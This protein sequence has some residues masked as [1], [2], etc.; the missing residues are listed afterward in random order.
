MNKYLEKIT[1]RVREI[2]HIDDNTPYSLERIDASS[3]V[4]PCRLDVLMK[5]YY[6]YSK[7]NGMNM[8]FATEMFKKQ[9]HSITCFSDKEN[10]QDYKN[11]QNSFVS[12]FDKIIDSI[13]TNGFDDEI[14]LIPISADNVVLDGA[15]RLACALYLNIKVNVIR[16]PHI[17]VESV[18]RPCCYDY[19]FFKEYLLDLKYIDLSVKE[20]IKKSQKNIY[21]ACLWPVADD[22]KKREEA[23][24]LIK[25]KYNV[26]YTKDCK[27]SFKA[28]CKF[29]AQVYMHDSWVGSIENDFSG[30][31][32]KAL[33]T[34]K[35]KGNLT[36]VFFEGNSKEE[37]LLF[38]DEVRK[39]F[40][41][42][43]HSVHITDNT[44]ET[45]LIAEIVLNKN[46]LD[47][48]EKSNTKL[49][50]NLIRKLY[51]DVQEKIFGVELSK[52]VYG[53]KKIDAGECDL[54]LRRLR[55]GFSIDD[56]LACPD[57]FY[58]YLNRKFIVP[59]KSVLDNFFSEY[60]SRNLLEE[61]N[62]WMHAVRDTLN[63][64]CNYLKMIAKMK[65]KQM[66]KRL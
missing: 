9:V 24:R 43:K 38:K 44:Q 66:L 55:Q 18:V 33:L 52:G 13:K 21:V 45:K 26:I 58:T 56:L 12:E 16:F 47:F 48:L 29:I 23:V 25:E 65:V 6:V 4:T 5:E 27:M 59:K 15:H 57:N 62:V 35:R 54:S 36:F 64:Y 30:S 46:S 28:F 2:Y 39:I 3:L 63:Y 49:N 31:A 60:D 34:Y 53:L 61:N 40:N 32:S 50:V 42:D 10:G 14:S 8:E 37:T 41:I 7:L 11:N 20:Y 22:A 17:S 19:N 1:P 51:N